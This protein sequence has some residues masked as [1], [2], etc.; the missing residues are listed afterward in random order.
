M[1]TKWLEMALD[2]V[3]EDL[4][5]VARIVVVIHN[6]FRDWNTQDNVRLFFLIVPEN[7]LKS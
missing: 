5:R 1:V 7:K 4:G 2:N 3:P 6:L